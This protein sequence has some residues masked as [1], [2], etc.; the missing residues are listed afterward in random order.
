M[1]GRPVSRGRNM[2]ATYITDFRVPNAYNI[3]FAVNSYPKDSAIESES[4]QT[5]P[6]GYDLCIV[7]TIRNEEYVDGHLNGIAV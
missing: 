6:I 4:L 7:G 5:S 2:N 1:Q 3:F